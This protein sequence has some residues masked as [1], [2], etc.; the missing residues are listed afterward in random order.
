MKCNNNNIK[1]YLPFRLHNVNWQV[2]LC[3]RQY[4]L[5]YTIPGTDVRPGEHERRQAFWEDGARAWQEGAA[6]TCLV[7]LCPVDGRLL[8]SLSWLG[9]TARHYNY[10]NTYCSKINLC[11]NNQRSHFRAIFV[12]LYLPM[13]WGQLVEFHSKLFY[14]RIS[15]CLNFFFY[16]RFLLLNEMPKIL[17]KKIQDLII[18]W[19]RHISI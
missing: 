1:T 4:K 11:C 12:Q 18:I 10:S 14:F 3:L 15:V 16:H 7:V 13:W 6:V 9:S 5:Q 19:R 17:P 8:A 2:N